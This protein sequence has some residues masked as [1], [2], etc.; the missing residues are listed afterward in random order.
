LVYNFRNNER[1]ERVHE[2]IQV[3]SCEESFILNVVGGQQDMKMNEITKERNNNET[4][5]NFKL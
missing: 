4:K 1:E 2:G 5:R 3:S